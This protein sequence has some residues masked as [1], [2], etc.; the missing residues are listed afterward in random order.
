[1]MFLTIK[2]FGA[3]AD[4]THKKEEQFQLESAEPSVQNVINELEQHY[5]AIKKIQYSIALNKYIAVPQATVKENDELALL[6][7][8][9]GG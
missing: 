8:F 9:A 5:P 6:P 3:L 1:M 2:Y 4:V 7:P